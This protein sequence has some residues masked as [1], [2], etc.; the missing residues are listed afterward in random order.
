L[1][2]HDV[3]PLA[4]ANVS[5]GDQGLHLFGG[6]EALCFVGDKRLRPGRHHPSQI[7]VRSESVVQGTGGS[8][9]GGQWCDV[10]GVASA[11]EE[12]LPFAN[13]LYQAARWSYS[14]H[15][16]DVSILF[17]C[18]HAYELLYLCFVELFLKLSCLKID[19]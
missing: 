9:T 13:V 7:L 6:E 11:R 1:C 19:Y 3:S 2:I 16:R 12:A 4:T 17:V 5:A 18:D 14:G 10:D 15:A 8:F